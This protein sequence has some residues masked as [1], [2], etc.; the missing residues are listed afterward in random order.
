M[1]KSFWFVFFWLLLFLN[2]QEK[3]VPL[4]GSINVTAGLGFSPAGPARTLPEERPNSLA[5]YAPGPGPSRHNSSPQGSRD[6]FGSC[7]DP[8]LLLPLPQTKKP[9]K[10]T[11]PRS[12]SRDG[13]EPGAASGRRPLLKRRR[14]R[15]SQAQEERGGSLRA[16]QHRAQEEVSEPGG[17]EG[18]RQGIRGGG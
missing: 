16:E 15:G 6:G 1:H 5:R 18:V 4:K 10:R 9:G 14:G 13:R 7:T 8:R 2:T 17:A 3:P 12:R 11:G